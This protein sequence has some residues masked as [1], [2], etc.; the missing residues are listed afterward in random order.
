[1]TM[2]LTAPSTPTRTT[3]TTTFQ[4]AAVA[5]VAATLLRVA[6]IFTWPPDSDASHAKMLATAGAHPTAWNLATWA[7]V[8]CWLSAGFAVLVALWLVRGRGFWPTRI[9]GWVYGASLVTLGFVGGSQNATTGVLAKQPH[10]GAMV[11]VIDDLHAS[12]ALAPFVMLVLF[13]ELFAIVFAV[14]LFR[15]RLVGWWYIAAS[16]LAVVA[17]VV[18]SDSSNHLV[19]LAGFVPLAATWLYLAKILSTPSV[20]Q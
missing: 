10:P 7:E 5:A 9:G 19:I 2:T 13:G 6:S 17:Y 20:E 15:A 3:P 4:V 1:M 11:Q 12:G 16:V 18:T 14:G 8:L